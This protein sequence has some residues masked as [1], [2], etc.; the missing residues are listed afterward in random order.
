VAIVSAAAV[1]NSDAISFFV[2]PFMYTSLGHPRSGV[3]QR[4]CA[5]FYLRREQMPQSKP[6]VSGCTCP[7]FKSK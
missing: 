1:A 5:I 2:D 4:S 3:S 7:F 6:A